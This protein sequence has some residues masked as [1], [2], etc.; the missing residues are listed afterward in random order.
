MFG[1]LILPENTAVR[2]KNSV[3]MKIYIGSV[4]RKNSRS[5]SIPNFYTDPEFF[6]KF[7]YY[8]LFISFSCLYFSAR[9]F[10]PAAISLAA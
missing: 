10:P 2:H 7:T 6:L 5:N 9:K 1:K 4:M 8:S 3:S